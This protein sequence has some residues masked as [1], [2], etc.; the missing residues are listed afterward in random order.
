MTGKPRERRIR[1]PLGKT[2]GIPESEGISPASTRLHSTY[3]IPCT[4]AGVARDPRRRDPRLFGIH[5]GY[6]RVPIEPIDRA[7]V[8]TEQMR[9]RFSGPGQRRCLATGTTFPSCPGD[10]TRYKFRVAQASSEACRVMYRSDVDA[11]A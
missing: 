8:H 11:P 5:R 2:F 4:V 1:Q 7:C 10:T 3:I 6:T 9:P